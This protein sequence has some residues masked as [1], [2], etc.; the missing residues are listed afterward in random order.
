MGFNVIS[1]SMPIEEHEDVDVATAKLS[2]HTL[3][4]PTAP[5][6]ESEEESMVFHTSSESRQLGCRG[7]LL[8]LRAIGSRVCLRLRC[9]STCC[10]V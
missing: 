5:G 2:D 8:S 10:R 3:P 9:R 6:R 4:N 1:V 7:I